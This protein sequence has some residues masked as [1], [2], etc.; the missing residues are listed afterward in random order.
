MP[1][2]LTDAQVKCFHEE[3]YLPPVQVVDP[4]KMKAVRERLENFER[5]R[6][7]LRKKLYQGPNVLFPWIYDLTLEP[8]IAG[9]AT[10]L[11]GPNV[12]CSTT[13]FRIKDPGDEAYI[14]WHQDGFYVTYKPI[15]VTSILAFTD[16]T[17]LHG[18]VQVIP[19]SHKGG[20]LDHEETYDG[21]NILTRGQRIVEPFD[22]SRAIHLQ[23][24]AGE[25]VVFHH[26]TIHGSQP[27]RSNERR[28]NMLID[29]LPT[30][31]K[32]EGRR[33]SATLIAGVDTFNYFDHEPRPPEDLDAA[34]EHQRQVL[35]NRNEKSYAGS[36]HVSP[37][38][39]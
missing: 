35:I 18:C 13:A 12:F 2:V 4:D 29:L 31:A 38:L 24:K 5:A 28:I 11:L 37:V 32:R 23:P 17:P 10:D 19:G 33:E 21:K 36:K 22:A 7:D 30:N 39:Q 16:Q 9:V 26:L 6:P 25:L 8:R 15:W 14:A 3:G 1:K 20:L 34:I 27:N